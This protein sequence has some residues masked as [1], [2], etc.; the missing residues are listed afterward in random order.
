MIRATKK[1]FIAFVPVL[2]LMIVLPACTK[3]V[4]E[5]NGEKV[6]K[7][8]YD[9]EKNKRIRQHKGKH[10]IISD[11]ILKKSSISAVINRVLIV[12]EASKLELLPTQNEFFE[13]WDSFVEQFQ[14]KNAFKEFIKENNMSVLDMKKLIRES[15]IM[16]KF[17]E[18]VYGQI[19]ITDKEVQRF[20]QE[21]NWKAIGPVKLKAGFIQ[22]SSREKIDTIA[23]EINKTV[24]DA[25]FY[26]LKRKPKKG[27]VAEGP[28]WIRPG[29]ADKDFL[30]ATDDI[31]TGRFKG[32]TKI[33]DEWYVIK[34]YARKAEM[35]EFEEA[36]DRL[37]E[38][39]RGELARKE[40]DRII[41]EMY[42]EADIKIYSERL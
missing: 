13:R 30:K 17:R 39:L 7:K 23:S 29:N 15:L 16:E 42:S 18:H 19:E 32:P 5:I 37:R 6:S 14:D 9:W 22:T 20:Y 26:D 10:V 31:V 38:E 35:P 24:F 41:N 8:V 1:R 34:V 11:E 25:V 12:Q 3:T 28:V 36:K 40:F 2:M 33:R 27:I 4:M 21:R